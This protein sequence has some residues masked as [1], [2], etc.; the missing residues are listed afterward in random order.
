MVED[1]TRTGVKESLDIA[2]PLLPGVRKLG[3]PGAG[4]G[5]N[6]LLWALL[7]PMMRWANQEYEENHPGAKERS[8]IYAGA[9]GTNYGVD[10]DEYAGESACTAFAGYCGLDERYAASFA[11][12][13]ILPEYMRF[14]RYKDTILSLP[15]GSVPRLSDEELA[16]IRE[17]LRPAWS[18]LAALYERLTADATALMK[19]HAPRNADLPVEQVVSETFFMNHVGLIGW[20]A[21]KAGALPIP[22]EDCCPAVLL[23]RLNAQDNRPAG[24]KF[25]CA[26]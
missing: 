23:L 12:F 15:E 8:P 4:L 9:N 17:I 14:N 5:E 3:F 6:R 20:A 19:V 13:N 11:D 10:Y 16:E 1:Y 21:V 24:M 26:K 7:W 18:R 25:D 2:R 22:E